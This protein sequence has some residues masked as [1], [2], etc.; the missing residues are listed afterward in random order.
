MPDSKETPR[1]NVIRGLLAAIRPA[2]SSDAP[3]VVE[4]ASIAWGALTALLLGA[5]VAVALGDP[6]SE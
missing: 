4:K 6:E 1:E 3:D 5:D 2:F